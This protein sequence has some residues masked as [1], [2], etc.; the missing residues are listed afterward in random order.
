MDEN[1][2][3][4]QFWNTSTGE[5]LGWF[6]DDY[7]SDLPAIG[8]TL[9]ELDRMLAGGFRPGFHIIGGNTGAG[10]SALCLWMM[11]RIAQTIDPDTG[12]H[13][14]C[15]YISL[16]L[17]TK[18]VMFRLLSNLSLVTD[19][20]IPFKWSDAEK[21][22]H[23]FGRQQEAGVYDPA[24]D[25]IYQAYLYF[26]VNLPRVRIVDNID[27]EQSNWLDSV[28]MEIGKTASAGGRIVFLD[29]LQC[30]EVWG[31]NGV[32]RE[33][34]EAMKK[35]VRAINLEG[36]RKGVAV[37]CISAVNRGKGGEM[38]KSSKGANPGSDIFRGSSWLEYTCLTGMALARREDAATSGGSVEEELYIVKNRRGECG[39]IPLWYCGEYGQ[40]QIREGM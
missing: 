38:R 2:A 15:T 22:G 25:P 17:S 37:V 21:F 23:T 9:G 27:D 16:E 11:S 34:Q 7:M 35:A 32:V 39:C 40:F 36:I 31:E 33:E 29:Y 26:M 3:L 1:E 19:G 4:E 18:E 5:F 20:L 14:G 10:K 12:N 6:T 13:M 28:L 24:R 30:V 8:S